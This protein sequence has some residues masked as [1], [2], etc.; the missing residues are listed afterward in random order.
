MYDAREVTVQRGMYDAEEER[1]AEHALRPGRTEAGPTQK[2][3]PWSAFST[4]IAGGSNR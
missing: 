3:A 2:V 4:R 1:R